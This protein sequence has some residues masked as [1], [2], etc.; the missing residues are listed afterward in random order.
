MIKFC[1]DFGTGPRCARGIVECKKI[2]PYKK[3]KTGQYL[4]NNNQI[5][6]DKIKEVVNS[7]MDQKMST[8]FPIS[9]VRNDEISAAHQTASTSKLSNLTMS[10]QTKRRT[11]M[12]TIETS[13]DSDSELDNDDAN[14]KGTFSI[15]L[16]F[17]NLNINII[18]ICLI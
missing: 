10:P 13:S 9:P 1:K 11:K 3:D 7:V 8:F 2:F 18:L 14:E 16:K 12:Q 17:L 5:T 15:K 4:K 6:I